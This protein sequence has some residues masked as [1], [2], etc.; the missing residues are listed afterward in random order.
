MFAMGPYKVRL[1]LL[2]D[3]VL[4]SHDI[5]VPGRKVSVARALS[6]YYTG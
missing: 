5:E 3:V 6:E 1:G 2:G 4:H